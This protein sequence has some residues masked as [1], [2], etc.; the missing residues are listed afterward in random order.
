MSPSPGKSPNRMSATELSDYAARV[1]PTFAVN[2][3]VE[4]PP[5]PRPAPQVMTKVVRSG[6]REVAVAATVPPATPEQPTKVAAPLPAPGH[7]G[8]GHPAAVAATASR[9]GQDVKQTARV[10]TG[11]QL[12]HIKGDAMPTAEKAKDDALR[13]AK[14]LLIQKL[15]E[16]D[17]PVLISPSLNRVQNEYCPAKLIAVT[18]TDDPKWEELKKINGVNELYVADV[19]VELTDDQVRQLRQEERVQT[20]LIGVGGLAVG[21]LVTCGLLRAGTAAGRFTRANV[22]TGRLLL[23]AAIPL[24]VLAL[25][26]RIR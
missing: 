18:V 17:P 16:L 13:K 12:A 23:W 19:S 5:S 15:A 21:A 26:L 8:P 3:L 25:L 22:P 1:G 7:P 9:A 10:V 2:T 14:V 4:P 20:G 6:P 11:I 24:L